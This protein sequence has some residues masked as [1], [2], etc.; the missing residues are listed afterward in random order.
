[1]VTASLCWY[2]VRTKPKQ[3]ARA[4]GNL[5]S[6][7][8]ETLAPKLIDTRRRPRS[9]IDRDCITPLFP[10]YLFARFDAARLL[11]KV[12]L[13]RGV[14]SVIG[15]GECAT[16]IDDSVITLLKS[17]VRDDGFVR[18]DDPHPGDTVRIV[19]GPLKSL[20][21]IFER[22]SANERVV[23]LLANVG[24]PVRL[25]VDKTAVRRVG[26]SAF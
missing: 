25:E 4:E 19:R 26:P 17:R 22:R 6:W 2:L 13:S 24:W 12:R 20:D 23:I 3:D 1:M 5:H 21:G 16:A 15:F 8:I 7:G 14:R 11:A 18:L 9:R 10:G